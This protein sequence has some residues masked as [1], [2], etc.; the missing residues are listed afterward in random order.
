MLQMTKIQRLRRIG[1]L[2]RHFAR[3]LAYYR[4]GWVGSSL[5]RDSDFWRTVNRNFLDVAVLEWCKLL[6]D[7]KARHYWRKTVRRRQEITLP[8]SWVRCRVRS[9]YHAANF[10][11]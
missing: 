11:P 5:V 1:L 10:I 2:C 4:A 6:G 9:L 8:G 7:E 3:N